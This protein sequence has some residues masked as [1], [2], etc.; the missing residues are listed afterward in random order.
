MIFFANHTLSLGDQRA[1]SCFE[2]VGGE[3]MDIRNVMVPIDFSQP[4]RMALDYGVDLARVFQ[5]RLTLV[6]VMEPQP[7]LE[8]ASA[9]EIARIELE[10]R[11]AALQQLGELVAPEDEDDLDLRIVL[12]SGN[13]K[14]EIATA[15]DDQNVDLVIL[16]THGRGRLGRLILGSTTEGLL[17]RLH[18]PVMTVSHVMAPGRFKRILLA[19]DLSDS[20][21]AAFTF[22]LDMARKL[23]GDVLALHVMGGPMLAAAELGIPTE[24]NESALEEVRRRLRTLAMEG[25]AQGV[26]VETSIADGAA[27]TSIMQA[28][29]ENQADLILLAI[30]SKGLIERRLLGTTAERVVREAPIPVLAVPVSLN[31]QR[32]KAEQAR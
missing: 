26:A 23:G 13:A 24:T 25:K 21:H 14:K 12:R 16:G 4:S 31:A 32:E 18:V 22:A 29:T 7:V 19:T 1:R 5:A 27:A 8:G 30:E 20:S 15:V 9:G 6:H 11:E 3:D 17:R 28:A 2:A 10:R